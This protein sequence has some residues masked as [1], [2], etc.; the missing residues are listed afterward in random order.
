MR[1][2][3]NSGWRLRAAAVA[4]TLLTALAPIAAASADDRTDMPPPGANNWACRSAAHPV[5]VVLV[6]G[7][8]ANQNQNWHTL[9]PALTRAGYCVYTV[10]VGVLPGLPGYG[11]LDRL[12]TSTRQLAAFV[13]V[14]MKRTGAKQLD[15]VGHSQG[16]TLQLSYL[17]Y[18]GGARHA[19]RIV[20][21]AGAVSA[22]PDAA[23]ISALLKSVPK[24]RRS[25]CPLCDSLADPSVYDFKNYPNIEY[26]N[27]ASSTDEVVNPPSVSFMKPAPN[28]RNVLVQSYCPHMRVGHDAMSKS[29]TVRR[30]IMNA[31]DPA[32]RQPVHCGPDMPT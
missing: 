12:G 19:R 32:T 20:N 30:M 26:A 16:A 24:E 2:E 29:P 8:T 9:S 22:S 3:L 23:G 6:H 10:T 13:A 21:L 5:P 17:R 27:I 4:A 18:Y 15:F 28:V 31:L 7:T 14:V 25:L 11:G 1:R